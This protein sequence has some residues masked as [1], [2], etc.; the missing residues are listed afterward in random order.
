MCGRNEKH[1]Y[2]APMTFR[3]KD[4]AVLK[5]ACWAIAAVVCAASPVSA[6]SLRLTTASIPETWGNPFA[7][8]SN[9]RYPLQSAVFDPLTRINAQG[10]LE[11]WLAER[12]EQTKPTTW[13]VTLRAGVRFSNGEVFDA[14][15]VVA[16]VA[17]LKSES[18][19]REAISRELVD[20]TTARAVDAL[21]VEIE[22]RLPDPVLP[23][24]LSLMAI[25]APGAWQKLGRDEFA[26]QPVGTGPMVLAKSAANRVD[27][28]TAPT[29]WRKTTIDG[30]S[31]LILPE[32]A[33]RRA[34]LSTKAADAALSTMAPVDFESLEAEGG[35]VLIDRIP[36]VVAMAFNT[37][38]FAPFKDAR[39]RRALTHAV[40]RQALVDV[41]MGGKT[42]VAGQPAGPAWFGFNPA[43]EPLAYDP[44][45][46]RRLLAE[47]GYIDGLEFALEIPTGAVS[48]PDVFQA[49]AGDLA[50]VGVRMSVLTIPQQKIY[51]NI[52]TGGWRGQAAAIP[53]SSPM[54]DALYPQRQYTCLWHAPW[55]CDR[56]FTDDVSAALA[57][58]EVER[59]KE[60]TQTTMARAHDL[61]QALF[62]Y[63][64]VSF[65]G[66]SA[67]VV[68]FPMDFGFIRYEGV[69]L[70]N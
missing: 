40:N 11:P 65:T 23:Y 68:E 1:W 26:R 36:A 53:F 58:G 57:A 8:T 39:V 16:A 38:N 29:S 59:R 62:L 25:P 56:A 14:A 10:A 22:T 33:A 50:K 31:V 60:L 2:S 5:F 3:R 15:A 41:I 7:S 52:Q 35:R 48:Y 55:F 43:V 6:A 67:R 28:N 70:R 13:R 69:R 18:G 34:A 46:A 63:E 44:E 51:E 49:V 12:W 27:L 42:R 64:T 47:A 45:L 61:A 54:F 24:R 17:Y 32:P 4:T 19:S 20:V 66:L 30:V 37:E 9:T 21:S